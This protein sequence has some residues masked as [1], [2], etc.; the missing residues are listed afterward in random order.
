[1]LQG[2]GGFGAH[3]H[4]NMEIISMPLQGALAHGDSTGHVSVIRPND[5]Q[6]M[7][8]GTG[9][10]HTERNR[11]AH[12]PVSFL[13]L[14]ILPATQNLLPRYA[15][16]SFDPKNWENKFTFLVRSRQ[17]QQQGKLWINQQAVI[18]RASLEAG[19]VVSYALQT[20]GHG[21]YVF[22]IEGRVSVA[23]EVLGRRDGMG[24]EGVD[25]LVCQG[26]ETCDLLLIEVPMR[27]P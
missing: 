9:I 25:Q 4:E 11:S 15:Q 1:M 20:P 3:G 27:L 26:L 13:Q 7:S 21:V 23:E 19:K 2:G 12:E 24:V 8:A 17:R 18:A 14:W 5:V 16:R 6:V 22:V 10:M